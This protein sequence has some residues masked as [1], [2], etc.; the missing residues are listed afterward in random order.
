MPYDS[1]FGTIL[2]YN[3]AKMVKIIY[4]NPMKF[5]LILPCFSSHP[6]FYLPCL[7]SLL[8]FGHFFHF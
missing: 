6:I 8:N 5:L 2:R 4:K 1:K 7:S 3:K